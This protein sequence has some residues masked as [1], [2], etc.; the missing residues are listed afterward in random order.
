LPLIEKF[1]NSDLFY[2]KSDVKYPVNI[3]P[4]SAINSFKNSINTFL[5]NPNLGDSN[6]LV[7]LLKKTKFSINQTTTETNKP[8]DLK[9]IPP[10]LPKIVN[11]IPSPNFNNDSNFKFLQNNGLTDKRE[12][13]HVVLGSINQANKKTD[14]IASKP[15][16]QLPVTTTPNVIA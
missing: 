16:A 5:K 8:H 7:N 1:K 2:K 13:P 6:Q 10:K 11:P 15:E 4:Q 9:I 14:F 12:I 3:D